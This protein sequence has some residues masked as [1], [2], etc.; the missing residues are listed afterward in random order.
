[1]TMNFSESCMMTRTGQR[2]ARNTV[3]KRRAASGEAGKG[4]G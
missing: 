3:S 4:V 2:E 1:M